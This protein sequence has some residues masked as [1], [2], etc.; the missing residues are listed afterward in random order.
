MRR[1][2]LVAAFGIAQYKCTDKRTL[3]PF[4]PMLGE[5]FELLGD[6]WRYFSEQVSHHPPISACYGESEHYIYHMDTHS[7]M[8]MAWPGVL[9]SRPHGVQHVYL[10]SHD[11]HYLI[12]RPNTQ[13]HNLIFG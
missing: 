13:V 8:G 6:G 4:N 2:L 3:K 1:L 7:V 11:E 9:T 5:T 12:S 10:K